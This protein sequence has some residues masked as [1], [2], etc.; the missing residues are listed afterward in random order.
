MDF[1]NIYVACVLMECVNGVRLE[2]EHGDWPELYRNL[3]EVMTTGDR[4]KLAVKPEETVDVLKLI[5]LGKRSSI[6][7]RIIPVSEA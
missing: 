6:K 2:S 4:T 7:G 1:I 3:Y 5:E